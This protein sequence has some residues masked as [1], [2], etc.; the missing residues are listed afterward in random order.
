MAG[1]VLSCIGCYGAVIVVI[2]YLN[3]ITIGKFREVFGC[4]NLI[5]KS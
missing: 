3:E 2:V 5:F 1:L 4:K